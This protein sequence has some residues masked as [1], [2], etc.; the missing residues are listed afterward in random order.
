[1]TR[2]NAKKWC[3]ELGL[4]KEILAVYHR[5]HIIKVMAVAYAGYKVNDL[6]ENGGDDLH[7]GFF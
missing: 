5:N 2:L 6:V 7:I 4:E 3:P 1:V